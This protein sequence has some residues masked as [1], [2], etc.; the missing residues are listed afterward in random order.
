MAWARIRAADGSVVT[1]ILQGDMLHP[2][3]ELGSNRPA[4]APIPMQGA[5][6]LA[7]CAPSKFI[8]LWN[9]Y[10]ASAARN[11]WAI[12][13]HPLYFLKPA[14]SVAGDGAEVFVPHSAG[15]VVFEGEL[16]IVIGAPCRNATETEAEAAIFGYTCI[17]DLTS[18]DILNADPAFP[19]W[20]RAKGFDG[21]GVIGPVIATDLDWRDLTI[22][23][24]VNRRERQSYPASDMILSPAEIV[25]HLSHDLTLLPGDVIAVG[26][27]IGTRPVKAGDVVSVVIDG[28]GSV[29]VTMQD[30]APKA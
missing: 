25:R 17:N 28:I 29:T 11:G 9:N 3:A 27:S 16:G 12:P 23:T 5:R 14:S 30:E 21:F 8:G 15:R 1:G 2:M 18:L 22:R 10:H 24:L 20:T 19:Q 4:G 6:L 26:T 7:P 13:T